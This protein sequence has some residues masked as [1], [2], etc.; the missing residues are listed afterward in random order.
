MSAC[1][2]R[3]NTVTHIKKKVYFASWGKIYVV[4][5]LPLIEH[6]RLKRSRD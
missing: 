2:I 6:K 3:I 5:I 4:A 1:Y